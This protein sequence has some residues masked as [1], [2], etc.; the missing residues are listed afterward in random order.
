MT[1]LLP[2]LTAFAIELA[3]WWLAG[4]RIRGVVSGRATC[5]YVLCEVALA[6][7]VLGAWTAAPDTLG[8]VLVAAAGM[9]GALAGW[10]VAEKRC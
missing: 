8:R 6:Y 4:R 10:R 5:A 2:A 7:G 3:A 1:N 9:A